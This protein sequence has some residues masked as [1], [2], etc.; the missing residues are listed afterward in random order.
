ME[1]FIG[2]EV[3]VADGDAAA[4]AVAQSFT[5]ADRAVEVWEL[6]RKV[7]VVRRAAE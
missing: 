7:G 5:T 6:D 1:H 3:V 2:A 4:I